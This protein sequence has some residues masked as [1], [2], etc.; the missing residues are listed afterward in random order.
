MA[1]PTTPAPTTSTCMISASVRDG[2]DRVADRNRAGGDDLPID[3][4]IG[5]PKG[6][7]QRRWNG[8]I[9]DAAARLDVRCRATNDTFDDLKPH[10][11]ANGDHAIQEPKLV[12]GGPAG[13][14]EIGAKSQRIDGCT[15]R[16][17]DGGHR[18]EIDDRYD[19]FGDVGEAVSRR[20]QN[21]RRA[22]QFIG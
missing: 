18:S 12:P 14:I 16:R 13:D 15:D 6:S 11:V 2:G 3:A 20:V 19:L 21:F 22:A 9:A 4:A 5:M 17:L 8:E 7:Q 10:T 1:S